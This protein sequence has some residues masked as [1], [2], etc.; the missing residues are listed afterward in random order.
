M[1]DSEQVERTNA[2]ANKNV[3]EYRVYKGRKLRVQS[4][5]WTPTVLVGPRRRPYDP[6]K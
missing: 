6:S 4:R 2:R 5:D 1:G 3:R